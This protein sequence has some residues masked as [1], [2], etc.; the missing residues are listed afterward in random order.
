MTHWGVHEQCEKELAELN[1]RLEQVQGERRYHEERAASLGAALEAAHQAP[2]GPEFAKLL[3]LLPQC[4]TCG[5]GAAWVS[6]ICCLLGQLV[7][8]VEGKMVADALMQRDA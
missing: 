8:C 4:P 2:P 5:A 1:H 7:G 6:R 3:G